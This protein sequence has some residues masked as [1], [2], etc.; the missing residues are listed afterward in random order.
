MDGGEVVSSP[1]NQ[2]RLKFHSSGL[3]EFSNLVWNKVR[4]F[5]FFF[6]FGLVRFCGHMLNRWF[7]GNVLSP[8]WGPYH[9]CA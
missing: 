7:C 2:R 6:L 1:A 5:Y 9:F 4:S 3:A 8:K